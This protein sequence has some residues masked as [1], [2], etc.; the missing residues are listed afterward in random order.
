MGPDGFV[1]VGQSRGA[2]GCVHLNRRPSLFS[3][4]E[5]AT[6]ETLQGHDRIPK[7]G[8][9]DLSL[10]GG[11]NEQLLVGG[12]C[13]CYWPRRLRTTWPATKPSPAKASRA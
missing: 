4:T 9:A 13:V 10:A 7:E 12:S 2:G 6:L 3:S 8:G 5:R 1:H 11:K